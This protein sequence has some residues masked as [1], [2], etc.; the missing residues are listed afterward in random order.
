MM[1]ELLRCRE[2]EAPLLV[3]VE[4]LGQ[5]EPQWRRLVEGLRLVHSAPLLNSDLKWAERSTPLW[6]RRA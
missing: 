4:L 3:K 1:G 6:S 2:S 5:A